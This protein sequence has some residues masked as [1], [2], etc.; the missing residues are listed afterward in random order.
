MRLRAG[1]LPLR[2]QRQFVISRTAY[3][4]HVNVVVSLETDDGVVGYGEAAPNRLYEETVETALAAAARLG[5]MLRDADEWGI[6]EL[7]A[8]ISEREAEIKKIEAQMSEPGFYDNHETSKPVIDRHQALMWEVGD[9][10]GQWEAL[11]DG[12]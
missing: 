4:E 5:R 8:R 7:E 1:R 9:L 2:T 3:A 6:E 11:Q 10:M 12:K